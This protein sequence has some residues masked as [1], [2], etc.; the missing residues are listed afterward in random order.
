MDE[1]RPHDDG[2]QNKV[3]RFNRILRQFYLNTINIPYNYEA[4]PLNSDGTVITNEPIYRKIAFAARGC[5][6][7]QCIFDFKEVCCGD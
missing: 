5:S 1:I 3:K 4:V 2:C 7:N 6:D